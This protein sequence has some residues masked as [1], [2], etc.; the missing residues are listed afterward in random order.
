MQ[1]IP[2]SFGGFGIF[3]Y[4]CP[5]K[6][7]MRNSINEGREDDSSPDL[8]GKTWAYFYAQSVRWREAACRLS[9]MRK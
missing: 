5:R 2:K 3:A 4:L 9:L 8:I 6:I 1:K 7:S